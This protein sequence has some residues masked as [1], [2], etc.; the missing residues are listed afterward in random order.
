MI[1]YWDGT[2]VATLQSTWALKMFA[3]LSQVLNDLSWTGW[4]SV[5]RRLNTCFWPRLPAPLWWSAEHLLLREPRRGWV[6]AGGPRAKAQGLC[7]LPHRASK[8]QRLRLE[9]GKGSEEEHPGPYAQPAGGVYFISVI[10]FADKQQWI[11][12]IRKRGREFPFVHQP[13]IW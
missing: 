13:I 8:E 3:I 2:Q 11:K 12:L 10:E 7:P 6:V 9:T 5:G 4:G 1:C